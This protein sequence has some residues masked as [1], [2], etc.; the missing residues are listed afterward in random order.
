[1]ETAQ[2]YTTTISNNLR[3]L[4]SESFSGKGDGALTPANAI[5]K[6]VVTCEKSQALR[7][8]AS[9]TYRQLKSKTAILNF[10]LLKFNLWAF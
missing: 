2:L 1:M 10:I 5:A 3:I 7:P 8:P 6:T 4:P 9:Q